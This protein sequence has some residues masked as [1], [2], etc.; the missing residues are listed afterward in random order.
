MVFLYLFIY[1]FIFFFCVTVKTIYMNWCRSFDGYE[2]KKKRKHTKKKHVHYV[3]KAL[4]CESDVVLTSI[5]SFFISICLFTDEDECQ[6]GTHNCDVNA[7]CSNT[8]GSFTCTCLPGYS[9]DGV[10]CSG[11]SYYFDCISVHAVKSPLIVPESS[12]YIPCHI[13]LQEMYEFSLWL[14]I[15]MT[16]ITNLWYPLMTV[17]LKIIH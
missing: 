14:S 3:N 15:E 13:P 7:K 1:L 8:I 5:V 4:K 6:N 12:V 10:Q 17:Q 9:G 11:E 2:K 16:R